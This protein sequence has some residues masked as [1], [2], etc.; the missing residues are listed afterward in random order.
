MYNATLLIA[1]LTFVSWWR[2]IASLLSS[3]LLDRI[4]VGIWVKGSILSEWFLLELSDLLY[5]N[6]EDA[7]WLTLGEGKG[8]GGRGREEGGGEEE[9]GGG[10]EGK[11]GG[12]TGKGGVGRRK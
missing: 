3:S 12:G 4:G 2:S 7:H 8:G 9:K 5:W 10:S 1:A 11:G 6:T